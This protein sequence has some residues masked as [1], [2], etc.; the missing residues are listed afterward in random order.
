M[1]GLSP[2][3]ASGTRITDNA[4]TVQNQ[5]VIRERDFLAYATSP[6]RSVTLE[7]AGTGGIR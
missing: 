2:M 6:S 3:P 5:E 1:M 7:G 4:M